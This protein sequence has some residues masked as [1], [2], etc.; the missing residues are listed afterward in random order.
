[1]EEERRIME[2]EIRTIA[3]NEGLENVDV[4]WGDPPIRRSPE[5]KPLEQVDGFAAKVK[6]GN[7][8]THIIFDNRE[9]RDFVPQSDPGYLHRIREKIRQHVRELE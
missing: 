7:K 6:V 3:R 1:M 2:E 9:L 8:T 5:G 4:E